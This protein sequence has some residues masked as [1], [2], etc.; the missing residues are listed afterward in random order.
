MIARL[1]AGHAFSDLAHN[2]RPLMAKHTGKQPFTIK[3]VQRVRI[4]MT[5]AGRHDLDENLPVFRT[6]EIEFDNLQRLLGFKR[7]S[8]T[9]L[10]KDLPKSVARNKRISAL[11][12]NLFL[13]GIRGE[14]C[15][16]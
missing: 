2:A 3:A 5:D 11:K 10:H 6:F 16:T 14:R 15:H 13:V 1:D 4:C 8:G 12:L 7:H 9:R